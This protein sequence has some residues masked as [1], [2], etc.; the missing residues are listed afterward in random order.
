MTSAPLTESS[1]SSR[2]MMDRY[3][4]FPLLC[5]YVTVVQF[6]SLGRFS[7]VEISYGLST[8]IVA[9]FVLLGMRRLVWA[10][11]GERVFWVIGLLLSYLIIPSVMSHEPIQSLLSP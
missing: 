10:T 8:V 3:L 1:T 7:D 5:L 4:L 2:S 9:I 6:G 11:I